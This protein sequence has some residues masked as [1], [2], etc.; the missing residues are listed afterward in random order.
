MIIVEGPDGAGKTTL[1]S[2]LQQYLGGIPIAPRVVSKE[3]RALVDM[4]RWVDENLEQGFQ[5]TLFDRH[6]LISEPIYG[7]AMGRTLAGFDDVAWLGPRMK[8]FYQLEPIII[9]CLPPKREVWM[10]IKE[11]PDNEVVR[12][13][14]GSI[15]DMYVARAAMDY[16]LSPGLTK[17]WD[18]TRSLTIE[19]RPA[20]FGSIKDTLHL[21][22]GIPT[23]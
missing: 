4:Q 16:T 12:D 5:G 17:V 15:Y 2:Q 19:G 18:Y 20:F 3:T 7:P 23:S 22:H 9:Y 13:H 21:K 14:I 10:N 11:D 1:I 8:R 6:R